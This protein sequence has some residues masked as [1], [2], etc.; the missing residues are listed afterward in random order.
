MVE[1]RGRP[2]KKTAAGLA[3]NAPIGEYIS[4]HPLRAGLG[5]RIALKGICCLVKN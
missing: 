3:R 5:F 4:I 2:P 1:K